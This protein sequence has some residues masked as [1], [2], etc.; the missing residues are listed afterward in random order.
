MW[1]GSCR[2]AETHLR[3]DGFTQELNIKS[4][5]YTVTGGQAITATGGAHHRRNHRNSPASRSGHGKLWSATIPSGNGRFNSRTPKSCWGGSK[6]VRFW[7]SCS[8]SRAAGLPRHRSEL[9]GPHLE[10]PGRTIGQSKG[11]REL[12]VR[13]F[14]VPLYSRIALYICRLRVVCHERAVCVQR[15]GTVREM[16]E[17]PSRSAVRCRP[18][19]TASC[20]RQERWR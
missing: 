14:A 9:A 16:K 1:V 4:L 18:Q 6:T 17:D 3:K 5:G 7:T 13:G 20:C 10:V 2:G 19:A 12:L 15:C 11:P 8:C